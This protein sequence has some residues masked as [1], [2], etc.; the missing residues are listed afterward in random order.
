MLPTRSASVERVIVNHRL[1]ASHS[2]FV[3]TR[4][5]TMMTQPMMIRRDRKCR[6]FQARH[7]WILNLNIISLESIFEIARNQIWQNFRK[8]VSIFYLLLVLFNSLNIYIYIKKKFFIYNL[9]NV[10][11]KICIELKISSHKM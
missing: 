4:S 8:E 5:S 9:W 6:T 3:S 2:L 11:N 10:R 7:G 1:T